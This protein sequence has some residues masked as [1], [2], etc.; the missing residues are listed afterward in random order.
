MNLMSKEDPL[1]IRQSFPG[2]CICLVLQ[3]NGHTFDNVEL[4]CAKGLYFYIS[5]L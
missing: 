2:I 5:S 4:E 1:V 3:S